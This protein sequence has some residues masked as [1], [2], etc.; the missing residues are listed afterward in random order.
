M[1]LQK[2]RAIAEEKVETLAPYCVR[3]EIA[4]SL[5]RGNKTEVG[6]IEIVAIPSDF[7]DAMLPGLLP[8]AKFIKDGPRYKQIALPEGINLDLFLCRPPA[9]WGVLFTIRT[10]PA[11]F[12]NWIVTQKS[13]GGRL[14][15]NCRV[16]EHN[17]LF[18]NG[19]PVPMPE[20][21]NFLR[22]LELE[23]IPPAERGA[24][25]PEKFSMDFMHRARELPSK[26]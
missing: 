12:S 26:A 17:Q 24:K 1:E 6:D 8:G 19:K 16:A 14:P 21:E 4:G 9:Q 13:R 5:R 18:R 23:G 3:I 11:V 7:A 25:V 22:L 20:E 15:S 2:A 10:G